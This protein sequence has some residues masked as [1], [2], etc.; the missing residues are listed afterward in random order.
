MADQ[1][2]AKLVLEH[3]EAKVGELPTSSKEESDWLA[4]LDGFTL[5][6]EEKTKFENPERRAEREAAL[7]ADKLHAQTVSLSPSNR[8]SAIARKAASQLEST[9][10][11]RL[12]D[13]RVLWF[14]S[15]GFDSEAKNMQAFN[16]LYGATQVFDLDKSRPMCD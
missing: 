7:N 5:L 13:A 8:L 1:S 12:H 3:W 15:V 9:A 11:G 6:V 10:S 14:S 2:I 16:T 4:T